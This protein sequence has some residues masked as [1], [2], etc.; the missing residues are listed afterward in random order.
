[1]YSPLRRFIS[2][3]VVV[4]FVGVHDCAAE[5]PA[6]LPSIPA[7]ASFYSASLRLGEQ[8]DRLV[9]SKAFATLRDL[10]AVKLAVEHLH[11]EMAKPD[12]PAGHI[13]KVLRDPRIEN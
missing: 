2:P 8:M 4:L 13:A 11:A 6:S 10:P 9:A 5:P 1:M 7:D 12:S 3:I